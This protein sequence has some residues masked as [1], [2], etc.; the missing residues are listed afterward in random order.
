MLKCGKALPLVSDVIE[1]VH[2]VHKLRESGKKH[3]GLLM[4]LR[5]PVL[6]IKGE[7]RGR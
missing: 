5:G 3:S 6:G 4:Q 7:E 1:C 2:V